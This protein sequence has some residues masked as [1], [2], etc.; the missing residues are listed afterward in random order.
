MKNNEKEINEKEKF[1]INKRLKEVNNE[2]VINSKE[3]EK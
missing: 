1:L 3:L 2:K